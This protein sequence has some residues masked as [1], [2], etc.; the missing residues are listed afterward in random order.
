M[1]HVFTIIAITLCVIMNTAC[2]KE[3]DADAFVGTYSVSTIENVVYGG[4]SGTL[5]NSGMLLISKVSANRV[6]TSGYFETY[7]EVVGSSVYFESYYASDAYGYFTAVFGVGTLN[8][9]VLTFSCTMSGKLGEN[10]VLYPFTST[11]QH[12]C[13]K[14]Q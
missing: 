4:N 11:C 7:G 10:G 8:G 12:T 9:N 6:K 14:Q 5:T 2:T 13:I 3:D 1:K